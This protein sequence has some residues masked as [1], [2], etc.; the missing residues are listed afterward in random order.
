[1]LFNRFN[2]WI[3]SK[4]TYPFSKQVIKT[5]NTS[6]LFNY[7]KVNSNNFSKYLF[8]SSR[9]AWN[10]FCKAEKVEQFNA[11]IR[12]SPARNSINR[13]LYPISNEV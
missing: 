11:S 3:K 12:Y 2:V 10:M 4:G 1:M 7:F 13:P 9:P 5:D 8:L 6:F